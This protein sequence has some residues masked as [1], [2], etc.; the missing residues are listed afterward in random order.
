MLSCAIGVFERQRDG[1]A[2]EVD[3]RNVGEDLSVVEGKFREAEVDI[4]IRVGL[5]EDRRLDQSWAGIDK[6]LQL[7]AHREP[8]TSS[9]EPGNNCI[10]DITG[11]AEVDG[12]VLSELRACL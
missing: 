6:E 9:C 4:V 12:D 5:I 1:N 2:D 10:D 3:V 11:A 7:C 8:D